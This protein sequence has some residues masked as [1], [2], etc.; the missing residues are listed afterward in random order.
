M[1]PVFSVDRDFIDSLDRALFR[2]SFFSNREFKSDAKVGIDLANFNKEIRV[3]L[4]SSFRLR[5][6][7]NK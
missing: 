3:E 7:E 2:R 6:I 4:L 5:V 1:L